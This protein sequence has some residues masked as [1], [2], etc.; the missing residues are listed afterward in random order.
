MHLEAEDRAW[1]ALI[2]ERRRG[3]HADTARLASLERTFA[4]A[5]ERSRAQVESN[6]FTRLLEQ[7]GAQGLNA[8]TGVDYTNYYYSLPSNRLELWALLEGSRMAFPVFREFYRERDVVIEER[9]MRYESS[10]NGRL[11]LE[12]I[13]AAYQAHPYGFGGIGHTSDL[14]SFS[15]EEGDEFFKKHYVAKNMVVSVVGS[16]PGPLR[17]CVRWP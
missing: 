13:T 10:P 12:F 2:T 3:M 11:I 8:S 15:R 16:R 7:A 6:E 4:E 5:Q 14:K 9:R 1:D 17:T